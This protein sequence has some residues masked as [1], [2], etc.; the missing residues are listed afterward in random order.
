KG[1]RRD[2]LN[3]LVAEHHGRIVKVMGDGVLVEFASAVNAVA[4]AVTLQQKIA[5]AGSALPADR[6]IVLRIGINLGEVV[7]EGSDIY[8]DGVNLAARLEEIAE[9]GRIVIS[10]NVHDDIVRKLALAYDALGE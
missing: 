8:G 9:P 1:G 4:C 2:I 10:R 6:R 5:E 3:P 7:V